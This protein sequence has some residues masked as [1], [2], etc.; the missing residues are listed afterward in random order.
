LKSNILS[1]VNDLLD[2]GLEAIVILEDLNRRECV[3]KF[4]NMLVRGVCFYQDASQPLVRYY[5]FDYRK[6]FL[7]NGN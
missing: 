4:L 3:P 6:C 7:L 1:M 5:V 2:L